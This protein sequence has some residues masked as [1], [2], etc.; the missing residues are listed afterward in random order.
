[1]TA[2]TWESALSTGSV[3]GR[4]FS[5]K[6]NHETCPLQ[7]S[8]VVGTLTIQLLNV[9]ARLVLTSPQ[10]DAAYESGKIPFPEICIQLDKSEGCSICENG[11]ITGTHANGR[12]VLTIH[13]PQ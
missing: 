5:Y 10:I 13:P 8:G 6:F 12:V 3:R 7:I 2:S 1:M 9:K 4:R 11:T